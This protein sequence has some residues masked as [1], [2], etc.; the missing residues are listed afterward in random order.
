MQSRIEIATPLEKS[1]R[2]A[3]HEELDIIQ[4]ALNHDTLVDMMNFSGKPDPE[5]AE[6]VVA[7]LEKGYLKSA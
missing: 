7:L 2:D 5:V 4:M 1:L 3:T 6:L